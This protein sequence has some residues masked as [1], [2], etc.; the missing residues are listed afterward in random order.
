MSKRPTQK[1]RNHPLLSGPSVPQQ[2]SV[3]TDKIRKNAEYE[4]IIDYLFSFPLRR[5]G[6]LASHPYSFPFLFPLLYC[7]VPLLGPLQ[8][9]L[10][11]F[12]LP[13]APSLETPF[14]YQNFPIHYLSFGKFLTDS[15]RS[16]LASVVNLNVLVRSIH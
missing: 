11:Y 13:S 4:A 9:L 8:H 14:L 10:S 1:L 6:G 15:P 16:L 3:Y 7:F 12:L 5:I 2:T